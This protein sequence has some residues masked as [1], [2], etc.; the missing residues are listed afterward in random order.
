MAI[1]VTFGKLT[2]KYSR[3]SY[4]KTTTDRI[5]SPCNLITESITDLTICIESNISPNSG[6][7][8]LSF[9]FKPSENRTWY[10]FIDSYETSKN[11]TRFYCSLDV[12]ETFWD[13][14]SRN[15]F[16]IERSSSYFSDS[17]NLTDEIWLLSKTK[18]ASSDILS[19]Q[20]PF[21]TQ[22]SATT[23][24]FTLACYST[25]YIV[26]MN[27]PP[28]PATNPFIANY[29]VDS[30]TLMNVR[31]LLCDPSLWTS[32]QQAFSGDP[33]QSVIS[34][35]MFPFELKDSFGNELGG[36]TFNLGSLAV[37]DSEN[38]PN[39]AAVCRY[40]QKLSCGYI[41]F[42]RYFKDWRDF[43]PYTT[44]EIW[45]PYYGCITV[46]PTPYYLSGQMYI[47]Y[48][49]DPMSGET[50]IVLG[51]DDSNM[52]D[53][54]TCSIGAQIPIVSTN[55]AEIHRSIASGAFELAST[56]A[57]NVASYANSSNTA[58][59]AVQQKFD[60][61]P[62][63][64]SGSRRK[65]W[66][67][68]GFAKGVNEGLKE[69]KYIKI[70]SSI[71][72]ALTTFSDSITMPRR[73]NVAGGLQGNTWKEDFNTPFARFYR[74]LYYNEAWQTATYGKMCM[75]TVPSL[76]ELTGFVKVYKPVF[77]PEGLTTTQFLAIKE[78]LEEG[79]YIVVE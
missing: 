39:K 47:T 20:T 38:R 36:A 79:F 49:V 13:L 57:L 46:D 22:V 4:G 26:W 24:C 17:P 32:L 16:M 78:I 51:S 5:V 69:S 70:G 42:N 23:K 15:E 37:P 29:A 14:F 35:T 64:G 31:D 11:L 10:Y 58:K 1:D 52:V 61:V 77:N 65:K 12:L 6:Y 9:K 60:E 54:V 44:V 27:Q 68:Q 74:P 18:R 33:L 72:S 45:L 66:E 19:S 59:A 63:S 67:A 2:G 55:M 71:E 56:I 50:L 41:P 40:R 48:Y 75:Q 28:I 3:Q 34:C 7:N 73:V 43:E 25:S 30:N 62:T 53:T 21:I 76:E 8:Y